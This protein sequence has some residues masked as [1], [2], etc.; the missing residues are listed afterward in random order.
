MIIE[1]N[2]KAF[3]LGIGPDEKSILT[4][5]E[6]QKGWEMLARGWQYNH[7]YSIGE[8]GGLAEAGEIKLDGRFKTTIEQYIE[9]Y[10][11]LFDNIED[12]QYLFNNFDVTATI[13]LNKQDANFCYKQKK[14]II[15]K[16]LFIE[17]SQDIFYK[18]IQMDEF[19]FFKNEY[20]E[21]LFKPINK[22]SVNKVRLSEEQLTFF[23]GL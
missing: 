23:K 19:E 16:H 8:R 21:F 7:W 4:L 6:T 13:T 15:N 5:V 14:E 12:L 20:I 3:K 11:Q 9:V 10:R 18:K 2:R 17:K 22:I 1:K